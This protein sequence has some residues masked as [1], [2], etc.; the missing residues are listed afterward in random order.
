M[1]R[2]T[3]PTS[4]WQQ[5]RWEILE[6]DDFTCQYCGQRAPNVPLQVDHRIPVADG[7]TDDKTNL[8]TVCWSCNQ[9]KSYSEWTGRGR[10]RG[11]EALLR[12]SARHVSKTQRM[13]QLLQLRP[14]ITDAEIAAAT[15][16]S[17]DSVPPLR[18]RVLTRIAAAFSEGRDELW[19]EAMARVLRDRGPLTPNELAAYAGF[20]QERISE[21]VLR[22]PKEAGT[23]FEC[24]DGKYHL[25][26]GA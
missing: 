25:V 3:S 23:V 16:L 17:V 4:R 10:G 26:E 6:R 8:A 7:G 22:G 13:I 12:V 14:D 20:T 19:H 11:T 18:Y 1:A 15:G 2:A 21:S 9:G 24:R 5:L